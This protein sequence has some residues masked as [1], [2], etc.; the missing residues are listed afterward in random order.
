MRRFV[1]KAEKKFEKNPTKKQV[2]FDCFLFGY[3]A[4]LLNHVVSLVFLC[5]CMSYATSF[6]V[7]SSNK[8]KKKKETTKKKRVNAEWMFGAGVFFNFKAFVSTC[9]LLTCSLLMCQGAGKVS[10]VHGGP[11]TH[12]H[13]RCAP[14][15]RSHDAYEAD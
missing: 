10:G 5:F 6:S 15:M 4:V 2:W 3:S 12:A 8:K 1:R 13:D 7:S 14:Q 9:T 11:G